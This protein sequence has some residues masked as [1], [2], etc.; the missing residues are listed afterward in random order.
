MKK[1]M[2]VGG[3]SG[4]H[5]TPLLAV[6]EA[7]KKNT[8]SGETGAHVIYVGQR[9]ES[10]RDVLNHKSIDTHYAIS[11]GKFRRYYGESFW[12]HLKDIKT[13]L[14]NIR[15]IFRFIRGLFNAFWILKKVRPDA[16]FLKG[17]F[18]CVPVG[19]AARILKVPY[20]THDSDA[21]P[22]LAN[23]LTAKHAAYNAT[24]LE[25]GLYPYDQSKTVKVG[26]PV[27]PHFS[28][29]DIQKQNE[30]KKK[31]GFLPS[32]I[33]IYCTGGGNGARGLNEM[34]A[35]CSKML[36]ETHHNL[37]ITHVSGKLLVEDTHAL[38]E[39]MLTS[40]D[41]MKRINLIGYTNESYMWS[42]AADIV[43]GRAGA[44][45]IAE[46]GIQ[47]K[48]TII[49]PSPFLTGGQQM[50]NAEVLKKSQ[51]ALIAKDGSPS[52]LHTCIEKL[53][54]LSYGERQI[55]GEKLHKLIE[56]GAADKIARLLVEM[57]K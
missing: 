49:V 18:V 40:T 31:L 36:F 45:T 50:H 34:L 4:G 13:I 21:V 39:K 32:D 47:A 25:P 52:E 6:A 15:D 9:G 48:P 7:L 5:I 53:L 16:I 14:L 26:V 10:L 30:A 51:A 41:L 1:Y 43:I 44:T 33:L 12:A 2:L 19:L 29:V 56:T 23:R 3:G 11:A 20:M 8:I 54:S 38:Y 57:T 37:Y 35:V 46:F 17:G 24:A 22:G 55:F 28:K 42:M 27:Q